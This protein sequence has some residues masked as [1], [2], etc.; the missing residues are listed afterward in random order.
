L[1]KL[2]PHSGHHLP[3]ALRGGLDSKGP[4]QRGGGLARVSCFPERGVQS[5]V[6]EVVKDQV[7]YAPGVESLG[8]LMAGFWHQAILFHASRTVL[9]RGG[10][11]PVTA[12]AS[13][14]G[15]GTVAVST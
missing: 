13:N 12:Q 4:Q 2:I 3:V 14:A 15:Y 11:P 6:G 8:L 10:D 5:L 9:A 1:G 7:N